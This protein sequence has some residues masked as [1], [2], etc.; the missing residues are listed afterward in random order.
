MQKGRHNQ[1]FQGIRIEVD[2]LVP[3]DEVLDR[4]RRQMGNASVP[5]SC[6]REGGG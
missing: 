1:P 2:T 5:G 4:L 3:F 6:T